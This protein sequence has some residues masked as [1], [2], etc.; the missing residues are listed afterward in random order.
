MSEGTG[1][2]YAHVPFSVTIISGSVNSNPNISLCQYFKRS[3]IKRHF[4]DESRCGV[5][6]SSGNLAVNYLESKELYTRRY[7]LGFNSA[8]CDDG[9]QY[10]TFQ[11]ASTFS[12][13]KIFKLSM[14]AQRRSLDTGIC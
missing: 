12:W 5:K 1:V 6:Y 10:H 11:P 4:K 14:N 7:I 8:T 9:S 13:G 3:N 2:P